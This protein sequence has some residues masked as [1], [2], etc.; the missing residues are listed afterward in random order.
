MIV[1]IPR[2]LGYYDYWPLWKTFFAELGVATKLSPKTTK[3]MLDFGTQH[4]ADGTCLPVKVCYGHV[5][6]LVAQGVDYVFLPRMVSVDVREY[7][8]PK[9]MGLPDLQQSMFPD[10]SFLS[11]RIDA[12]QNIGFAEALTVVGQRLGQGRRKVRRAVEQALRTQE[13]YEQATDLGTSPY[14]A[15][16]MWENGRVSLYRELSQVTSGSLNL[17]EELAS[18]REERSSLLLGLL[19]HPYL[20]YDDHLSMGVIPHLKAMGVTIWTTD[21]LPGGTV[22][23]LAQQ[24][25]KPVFWTSAK[26]NM[27]A[28]RYYAQAGFDGVIY[29]S[30]F[31]CGT[32]SMVLSLIEEV[33]RK[34]GIPF[35]TLT[36]DEHTG[37][38]GM[39]TRLEA[40]VDMIRW[41]VRQ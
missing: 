6:H 26:R 11:P 13:L 31:P 38:A 35:M 10:V 40:F 15:L 2:A 3:K 24:W 22:H 23:Q 29:L 18:A 19:G 28:A 1:G 4:A 8:C 36:V 9:F 16:R 5:A 7:I 14:D 21:M 37:E 17:L 27:G 34:A 30:A 32:D 25:T 41:R 33:V 39:L 12:K 20:L